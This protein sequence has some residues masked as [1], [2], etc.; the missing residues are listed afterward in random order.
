MYKEIEFQAEGYYLTCREEETG[1]VVTACG[2]TAAVVQ[3]PWEVESKPV[4]GIGKK[5]FLSRKNIRELIL[6]VTISHIGDWAFAYCGKLERVV[7]PGNVKEMGKAVFANC[8]MLQRVDCLE[9]KGLHNWSVDVSFLLAAAVQRL[10]A[11]YLLEPAEAGN[12]EW[13]Q[14]WDA[15]LRSV[16]EEEDMEGYQ[17]Q[18]L[19]GEEDYGSTDLGAFLNQKRK[20][21]ARLSMLRLRYAQGLKD[22]FRNYLTA[23]LLGHTKG[24]ESEE[25]WQVL[26]QECAHDRVFWELFWQLGCVHRDNIESMLTDMGEEHA[27]MKAYFL[28]YKAEKLGYEDFFGGLEL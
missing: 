17:R 6:P 20:K 21:K 19:C 14:K 3:I 8:G 11:Y 16:M 7:L 25:A 1:L 15:R 9:G 24:C 5:A 28:R 4:V 10:D 23:Y 18:I 13:L 26:L 27:E 2:G 22:D 12:S